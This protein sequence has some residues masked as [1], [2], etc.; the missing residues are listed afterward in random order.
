MHP[1]SS[2]RRGKFI[3][4][5]YS[6]YSNNPNLEVGKKKNTTVQVGACDLPF[7]VKVVRSTAS[8]VPGD[9]EH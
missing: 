6:L 3:F 2:D 9:Y 4:T 5:L 7:S 8:Q 1:K